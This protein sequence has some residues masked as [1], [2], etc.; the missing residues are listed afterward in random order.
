M[1]LNEVKEQLISMPIWKGEIIVEPL[2]GGITNHNYIIT[3]SK[4]KYVARFGD[5][6][7]HHQVMRFNELAASKAAFEAGIAPKVIHHEKGL[8]I[9]EYIHSSPITLEKLREENTL[10][11]IIS[12]MKIIHKKI[13]HYYRGPAMIF[14]VFYVIKDYAWTLKKMHSPYVDKLNHLIEDSNKFEKMSGPYE[15]VFGHN[16]LLAANILDDGKKLWIIDWEYAGFNSP[17]F[18][19]GGLASNNGLTEDEEN[20]MLEEYFGHKITSNFN[21]KYKAMKCASILRELMWSMVSE[22]TSDIEF[23]FNNYTKEKFDRYKIEREK[24]FQ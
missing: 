21:L 9:F 7:I 20:F 13:P 11:K 19:L 18:D 10:K 22:I 2:E 15:I 23:D 8:L 3:D 1:N 14:W 12:L 6:L 5:D 16:D 24:F 4:D 17:L